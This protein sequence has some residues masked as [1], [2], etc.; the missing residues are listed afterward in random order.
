LPFLFQGKVK[1]NPLTA[2]KAMTWQPGIQ[3]FICWLHT[4]KKLYLNF[5]SSK[6]KCFLRFLTA[7]FD[8][9]LRKTSRFLFM[10]RVYSQK[11]KRNILKNLL[12]YSTCSQ[13]WLKLPLDHGHFVY[14]S[15]NWLKKTPQ[16]KTLAELSLYGMTDFPISC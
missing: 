7:K 5:K 12:L 8:Q 3:L 1:L 10:L 15:Q 4:A 13:M 6:I 9:N 16:K 11:Y 2:R 14:R